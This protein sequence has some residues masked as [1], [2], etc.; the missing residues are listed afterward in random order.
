MIAHG[1]D[2]TRSDHDRVR[3]TA[4]G[5]LPRRTPT[6]AHTVPR[7]AAGLPLPATPASARR[8]PRTSPGGRQ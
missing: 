5:R 4:A 3:R 1:N 8:W 2:A 7:P 6:A